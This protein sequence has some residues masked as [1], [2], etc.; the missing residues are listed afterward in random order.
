MGKCLR[1]FTRSTTRRSVMSPD[2]AAIS[3]RVAEWIGY[4][5][6]GAFTV[7]LTILGWLGKR[8][9]QRW[10]GKIQRLESQIDRLQGELR[11]DHGEVVGEVDDLKEE[12]HALRNDL[13][14]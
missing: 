13:R 14:R 11:G 8:Q 7:L 6:V 9:V 3:A 12:V 1:I 10:E 4:V 2:D 5:A